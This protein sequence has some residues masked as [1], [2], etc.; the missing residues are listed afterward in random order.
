MTTENE[1]KNLALFTL[2]FVDEIDFTDTTI[3]TVQKVNRIYDTSRDFVLSNYYW[4]FV[5]KR[6]ILENP[7]TETDTFTVYDI[8][9]T[10]TA[11][12]TT[13]FITS[14]ATTFVDGD[15]I[16]LTTSGTLPA[17]LSLA[18][19][20]Y[21]IS[22]TG[23]TCQLSLTSGGAA[24]DITD[25]GTGT[26][27]LTFAEKVTMTTF[28]TLQDGLKIRV[29]AA[30]TL[31]TGLTADTDYYVTGSTTGSVGAICKLSLTDA[32]T[33]VIM[34]DA[35]TGTLTMTFR[36][37]TESPYKYLF[38]VPSDI[39]ALR[40]AFTDKE[41]M[42]S[43]RDYELLNTG[44]FTDRLKNQDNTNRLWYSADLTE[45]EW[46]QY[47]VDY[48]KYKLAL[49][50]CFN[51]TG[52]TKREETLFQISEKMLLSSK[53]IDAKQVKSRTVKS[54]PFTQIRGSGSI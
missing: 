28:P 53:N 12:A 25:T 36:D 54:S 4:R 7:I 19:N 18:T 32:G 38:F 16:R 51:L 31:P 8:T 17:G 27:T 47:F 6:A 21:V 39:L 50:L 14:S 22:S 40:H 15:V 9:D 26:H 29:A 49:D 20:Y 13:E 33:P 41:N 2:G 43:I 30:T 1:M 45:T 35:G 11:N 44:F 34:T 46:P 42:D 3:P 24:I 48:F 52:D 5:M 23:L 37:L 10:F